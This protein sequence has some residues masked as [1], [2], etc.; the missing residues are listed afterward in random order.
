MI[1][2]RRDFDQHFGRRPV[3]AQAER[4]VTIIETVA[5]MT[6]LLVAMAG[7]AVTITDA[8][9]ATAKANQTT[10]TAL[11]RAEMTDRIA[12][13]P[14]YKTAFLAIPLNQ[15]IPGACYT[16]DGQMSGPP[17]TA[18]NPAYVCPAVNGL[19]VYQSW[20]NIVQNPPSASPALR[21]TTW[22]YS[23]YVERFGVNTEGCTPANRYQSPECLAA[24]MLLSD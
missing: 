2:V 4:G 20:F 6:I 22:S 9:H 21:S 15:W 11:M 14:R 18:N 7:F 5:A 13:T 1:D 8:G 10:L 12:V 16:V 3:C 23:T 17:N 24:D 19:P